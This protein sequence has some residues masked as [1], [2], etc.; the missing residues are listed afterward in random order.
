[1]TLVKIW[2]PY[3]PR[4][5]LQEIFL[6]RH[7]SCGA[8]LAIARGDTIRSA[9]RQAIEIESDDWRIDTWRDDAVV[10]SACHHV[11]DLVY[12]GF[13]HPVWTLPPGEVL[14]RYDFFLENMIVG[15]GNFGKVLR[16]PQIPLLPRSLQYSMKMTQNEGVSY[17]ESMH[18]GP[19]FITYPWLRVEW[20]GIFAWSA[21]VACALG[22]PGEDSWQ[23]LSVWMDEWERSR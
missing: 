5:L 8:P 3:R 11:T 7:V 12:I 19:N 13:V 9:R 23:S 21:M 2:M 18:W 15:T 17:I 4:H 20:P 14:D 6:P 22:Q 10:C 16:N 1:M